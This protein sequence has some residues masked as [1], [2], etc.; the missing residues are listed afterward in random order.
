MRGTPLAQQAPHHRGHR[1]GILG[2]RLECAL[3][4][5]GLE[6][7]APDLERDPTGGE[8]VRAQ[9][10]G[11][12]VG[13]RREVP[14]E[15]RRARDVGSE[16]FLRADRSLLALRHDRPLI[17]AGSEGSHGAAVPPEGPP[18]HLIARAPRLT[19][20]PDA[21]RVHPRERFRTDARKPLDGQGIEHAAQIVVADAEQSVRLA[22]I[23][24]DLG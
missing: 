5:I 24:S 6:I 11:G 1:G 20:R 21:R 12:A 10:R 9:A 7:G 4:R 14:L 16:R 2:G 15:L 8:F 19:E 13:Q 23:G 3:P 18:Q 17:D 22:E